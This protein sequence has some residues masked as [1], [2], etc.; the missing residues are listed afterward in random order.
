MEQAHLVQETLQDFF[1]KCDQNVILNKSKVVFSKNIGDTM[2]TK[3]S[4]TLE[5]EA[6]NDFGSYL[7]VPLLH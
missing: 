3:I 1:L 2:A 5:I 7:G 4:A 6:T